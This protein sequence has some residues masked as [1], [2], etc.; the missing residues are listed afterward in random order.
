M[1]RRRQILLIVLLIVG[2]VSPATQVR[3]PNEIPGFKFYKSARWSAVEPMVTSQSEVFA[4]LGKPKQVFYEAQ[5]GWHFVIL[6]IE[7]GGC[8]DGKPWA[9]S[10]TD[11][12][13][14]VDLIPE[15]RVSMTGV[16]FPSVFTRD[17][18]SSPHVDASWYSYKD[19]HGLEYHVFNEDSPD[20]SIRAGDLMEIVYGP[21]SR[22]YHSVT[23]CDE[24]EPPQ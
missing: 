13:A 18:Q 19:V 9:S 23:G 10:L 8:Y 11:K 7:S 20:G 21:S 3:Y 6:Y 1:T 17:D 22:T 16:S 12:V 5:S 4:L 14:H 24:K 15:D 2:D